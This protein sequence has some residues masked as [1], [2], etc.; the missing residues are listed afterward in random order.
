MYACKNATN[1]SKAVRKTSMKNGRIAIGF[2]RNCWVS[3][4]TSELVSS[5]KVTSRMCPASML[6]KSRTISENGR[7]KMLEMNSIGVT[8]MYRATGTPGGNSVLFR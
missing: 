5:A 8:R 2:S 4:V 1:T 6:A 3:A 7:T